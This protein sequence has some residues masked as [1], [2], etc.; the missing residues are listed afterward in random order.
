MVYIIIFLLIIC[1]FLIFRLFYI[2][3]QIKNII[4]QIVYINANEVDKKITIGLLN[5]KIEKLAEKINEIIQIKKQSEANKVKLENDL[6]Q[7]IANMSH[8]LRTPLTS[9]IGYIQFLKLDN[10]SEDE[11]K[12]YLDIAE[13]RAKALEVL[14]NDFYELSLIESL[15]YE[16]NLEKLNINK[17]LQECILGKYTDFTNRDINP[18]IEI[19][20]NSIYI[21]AEEKSLQRVIENL[22]SN[23]VKYAKDNVEVCLKLEKNT[24]ILEVKNTV[25]DLTLDDVKNIFNRFYMADKIRS[26]KGTG[27]GLAIVRGL[28]HKMNGSI[29]ADIKEDVLSICCRFQKV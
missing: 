1:A 27:L 3:G 15:D 9:I 17:I 23:S 13:K 4:N 6:R 24:A 16:L 14:L 26:G 2:E 28:V 18:R 10:I 5:K 8:D 11:K 20:K 7:T 12:E 22:L 25:E 19:P 29:T 21:I